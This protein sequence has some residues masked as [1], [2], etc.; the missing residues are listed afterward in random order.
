MVIYI[1]RF[2]ARRGA[3]EPLYGKSRAGSDMGADGG[4]YGH[5]GYAKDVSAPHTQR[6]GRLGA[7][8]AEYSA[9]I[10]CGMGATTAGYPGTIRLRTMLPCSACALLSPSSFGD[11]G[12]GKWCR[13]LGVLG[14]VPPQAG[15]RVSAD[16]VQDSC[17]PLK[18]TA[19]SAVKSSAELE[20]EGVAHWRTVAL[21]HNGALGVLPSCL[22]MLP[23][24]SGEAGFIAWGIKCLS[25]MPACVFAGAVRAVPCHAHRVVRVC[26][27]CV[28]CVRA[29]REPSPQP[30]RGSCGRKGLSAGVGAERHRGRACAARA[31]NGVERVLHTAVGS[32]CPSRQPLPQPAR[33]G[34]G[35]RYRMTTVLRATEA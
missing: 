31:A 29:R 23:T 30:A 20:L 14:V 4:F 6:P 22:C 18:G 32:P 17:G 35:G 34:G 27:V 25:L 13:T 24:E 7:T 26:A 33:A 16:G 3:R 28:G 12:G 10:R 19:V 9:T 5:C 21:T 8:R 1:A 15:R 11:R 2:V